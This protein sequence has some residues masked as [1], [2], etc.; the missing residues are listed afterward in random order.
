MEEVVNSGVIKVGQPKKKDIWTIRGLI[1]MG[2]ASMSLFILWFIEPGH[3]GY[4][5]IYWLLTFALSFKLLKMIQ[6]WYHY[7]SPSVPPTPV[8]KTRFTVDI[9]TT[10][11]PGE[12][13]SMIIRTLEA[14]V[15]IRYPH[16]NY[17]CDEGDDPILKD[18]CER[19][20][21]I[22]VTRT[23][24]TEAKAGNINNALRQATGQLCV[25]LDP[26]H[27]PEPFFLERVLPYFE[28][29]KVGYVQSVQA[30]GNQQ[31]SFIARGAAEQSYHF[32]G[33]MMMCM[34]SYGTVQAIGANC[35]FRREAL[36]SIGGHAAGL[37]ED[38]HT[39]MQLQAKK[40]KPVYIPE[41]L[42]RGLAPATLG[43]YYKQQLK[44]SRGCFELLF[45]VY[46]GL[47]RKFTLRQKIHHF[48]MPLYFLFGLINLI[49]L[50]IPAVSLMIARVPWEVNIVHFLSY[51]FIL[52]LLSLFIRLFAQRW[53]LERHEK[54]FHLAAGILRMGTWWIFLVGF[55]YA[56]F[57]IKVPYLPTPKGD[58]QQD[59]WRLCIPNIIAALLSVPV[60]IYGLNIDWT[61]YS[62]VMASYVV[63]NILILGYLVLISQQRTLAFLRN[64]L[65]GINGTKYLHFSV[66]YVF[67]GIHH[68]LYRNLSKGPL[69][70]L[71]GSTLMF[72][73][74]SYGST[75]ANEELP[76][77]KE[78]GGFYLGHD[79]STSVSDLSSNIRSE[80][81]SERS[82]DVTAIKTVW[83][84]SFPKKQLEEMKQKDIM[85]LLNWEIPLKKDLFNNICNGNSDGYL[86]NVAGYFR[87]FSDPVFLNFAPGF[88]EVDSSGNACISPDDLIRAWRYIYTLFNRNGI[89]N[90]TWVWN[91][92]Y[93]TSSDYYP[94]TQF[95]DWIGIRCLNYG[96]EPDDESWSSFSELYR[97]FRE[98]FG[99]FK[100]PVILT[101]VGSCKGD[102]QARWMK[103]VFST[104][105][106]DLKEI[107]SVILFD[108]KKQV[109]L[110]LHP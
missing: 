1:V 6:E 43:A 93:P 8:W 67:S 81:R 95:V 47:F 54:G 40:W 80:K 26:D 92:S 87:D 28:D 106:K 90:I 9:L 49:D 62:M 29:P 108:A 57:N 36:D 75:E 83:N 13:T 104:I 17:L 78:L 19:L 71:L 7:W 20:G 65:H 109:L 18:A 79:L 42:T 24:K 74:N 98:K 55:I 15:A 45:R 4:G 58:E 101:A 39:A 52:C 85:P 100:K 25:I 99:A 96:R 22:H 91:P 23:I 37:A 105:D 94:G 76:K 103:D 34:N 50:L 60:I 12:P 11:C 86:E 51:Y 97:P 5:P 21:V 10:A 16:T 61:P 66:R 38:M 69:I 88:D 3:Q 102:H 107:R 32:Y 2:L 82:F 33:P 84:K 63:L 44:W 64:K 70:I 14:M 110:H 41:I 73:S 77:E 89:S 48:T 72:L 59:H 27:E 56:I 53:L 30:Y 68:F 31:E 35:I 46:P